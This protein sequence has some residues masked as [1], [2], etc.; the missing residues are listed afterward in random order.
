MGDEGAESG[1]GSPELGL[2]GAQ[3][4]DV[5]DEHVVVLHDVVLVVH[6]GDR[7]AQP[8][9][10]TVAPS[11]S[12]LHAKLAQGLR[13]I[14]DRELRAIGEELGDSQGGQLFGAPLDEPAEALVHSHQSAVLLEQR[15]SERRVL[16]RGFEALLEGR[17][18]PFDL[19]SVGDVT[20]PEDDAADVGIVEHVRG[21]H[22]EASP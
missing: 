2:G 17:E 13:G 16:E 20:G 21:D 8:G 15:A 10:S 5:V 11:D 7:D 3:L 14:G 1:L 6:G 4:G 12:G 22:L 19:G 18:S 9:G